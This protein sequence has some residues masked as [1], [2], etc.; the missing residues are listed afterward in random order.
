[1]HSSPH[2][3]PRTCPRTVRTHVRTGALLMLTML[4]LVGSGCEVP[5]FLASLGGEKVKARYDLPDRATLVLVDDPAGFFDN[6]TLVGLIGQTTSE[7]L[8]QHGVIKEAAIIPQENLHQVAA[9]LGQDY[10]RT[11]IDQIGRLTGAQQV[12]HISIR[13][14]RLTRA[15]GVFEPTASVEVKVIDAEHSR[16][17]F[18]A[19]QSFPGETSAEP[20]YTL[21]A[22]MPVRT[23]DN[24]TRN[25]REKLRYDLAD[26]TGQRMAQLFYNHPKS[27]SE[28]FE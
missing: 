13:E 1:M 2:P 10:P 14:V 20:G 26:Y 21:V 23:Y 18:P 28:S 22:Q 17:L 19:G 24:P 15:P 5:G 12:I 7:Q 27:K 16:R 3:R 8:R 6:A 9:K 11:A 4:T 25:L